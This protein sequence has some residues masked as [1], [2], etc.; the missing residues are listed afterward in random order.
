MSYFDEQDASKRAGRLSTASV[1]ML[2]AFYAGAALLLVGCGAAWLLPDA[3]KTIGWRWCRSAESGSV[4]DRNVLMATSVG[5]TPNRAGL[6]GNI[7]ATIEGLS[8]S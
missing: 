7:D 3:L 4:F 1:L 2:I 5:Y 6:A 8:R